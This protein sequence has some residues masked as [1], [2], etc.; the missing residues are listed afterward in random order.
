MNSTSVD[1]LY[2]APSY[3]SDPIRATGS[4]CFR[5]QSNDGNYYFTSG[6]V[7]SNNNQ[8]ILLAD[9]PERL[10]RANPN[11]FITLAE[12][13]ERL[14]LVQHIQMRAETLEKEFEKAKRH[15]ADEFERLR[16]EYQAQTKA[17]GADRGFQPTSP[18]DLGT[19][20]PNSEIA[21]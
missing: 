16:R 15:L 21:R 14:R 1:Y 4:K 3:N 2:V 11:Q 9:E 19:E 17:N 12:E 8:V 7:L 10:R 18:K 5:N 6:N 13:S 20:R